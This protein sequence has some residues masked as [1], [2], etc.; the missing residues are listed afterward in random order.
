MNRIILGPFFSTAPALALSCP[1]VVSL[2]LQLEWASADKA[3]QIPV[4]INRRGR[5]HATGPLR[6]EH[7]VFPRNLLPLDLE[8]SSYQVLH[9]PIS[10]FLPLEALL[11]E[12]YR[13]FDVGRSILQVLT[14]LAS[15]VPLESP[16]RRPV[17]GEGLL[18]AAAE[19]AGFRLNT[20]ISDGIRLYPEICWQVPGHA[21]RFHACLCVFEGDQ[22]TGLGQGIWQPPGLIGVAPLLA[23][24]LHRVAPGAP[25]AVFSATGWAQ[26]QSEA[27]EPT[28]TTG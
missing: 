22:K 4:F 11:V 13:R 18:V 24:E 15:L 3:N 10:V 17:S 19:S 21:T 1:D 14:E 27:L 16:T 25:R 12:L 28:V 23:Y 6:L 7:L 5:T 2:P 26:L 20:V 8:C 9:T